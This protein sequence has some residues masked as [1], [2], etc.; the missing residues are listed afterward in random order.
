[1]VR[2]TTTPH[3]PT[4]LLTLTVTTGPSESSPTRPSDGQTARRVQIQI[5]SF[6]TFLWGGFYRN[7]E[8][9]SPEAPFREL[10]TPLGRIAE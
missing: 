10:Q 8:E 7:G 6:G 5:A 4:S 9:F 1:M 2:R 3:P